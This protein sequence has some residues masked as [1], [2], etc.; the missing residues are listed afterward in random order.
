MYFICLTSTTLPNDS[1]TFPT[2]KAYKTLHSNVI[3][4]YCDMDMRMQIA[5][6]LETLE[7]VVM[8]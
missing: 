4:V 5:N 6:V 7:M 2:N 8:K 1:P 3:F